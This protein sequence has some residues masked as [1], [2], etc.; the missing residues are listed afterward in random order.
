MKAGLMFKRLF[1]QILSSDRANNMQ[2]NSPTTRS[3]KDDSSTKNQ[4][5]DSNSA[6]DNRPLFNDANDNEIESETMTRKAINKIRK[7]C[8]KR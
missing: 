5:E 1:K 4:M 6:I 2:S 8:N 3:N 7:N